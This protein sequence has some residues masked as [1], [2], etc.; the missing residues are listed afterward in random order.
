MEAGVSAT[1]E[2]LARL[3]ARSGF[4]IDAVSTERLRTLLSAR[5]T[6]LGLASAEPA[7]S[8]ALRDEGEYARI[9]AHFAPP[10]TWLF[11]YPE[12]F[13]LLRGLARGKPLVRALA[14]GA[15]GWCEPV[16]MA[17][18]LVD[19][20]AARVRVT[21]VDRNRALFAHT[22]HHA[23]V[24]LRGGVPAWA[25]RFFERDARGCT[26]ARALLDCIE[27]RIGDAAEVAR[28]LAA[29]GDRFDVVAF[30]N[31]AIYM[32]DSAR[33]AVLAQVD[34]LLAEGGVLLVGHA[35]TT[36]AATATGLSPHPLAGAF[37]LQRPPAAPVARRPEP[38]ARPVDPAARTPPDA[39]RP[40]ARPDDPAATL[41]AAIAAHPSD[42]ALHLAL[43]R[44]LERA[45]D[46]AAA[47][48]AV[49]RALYLDRT[50][51]DALLQ[52]ARLSEAR[53][54]HADAERFRQRALRAHLARM[55]DEGRA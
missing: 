54:A 49:A 30:R 3:R 19:G 28:D 42:P 7:A 18:A 53:G 25:E 4:S 16:A 48:D 26:P 33:A 5:A 1:D 22:P 44:E 23:G 2:L 32:H 27:T 21:A 11:R 47:M 12:S 38:A 41:H 55:R 34:A 20:G 13:E 24:H 36:A 31:V 10:E 15:G 43:A 45:G 37:A 51:E 35:E 46:T 40:A 29:R 52:A 50:N 6:E 39:R 9:E 8:L 17:A 14:L